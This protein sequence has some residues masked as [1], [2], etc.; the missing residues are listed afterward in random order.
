MRLTV[1][2]PT[3]NE[4]DNLRPMI[5]VLLGLD[6]SSYGVALDV[7]AMSLRSRNGT[8]MTSTPAA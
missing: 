5:E 4:A 3:Y 1:V 2:L 6:L 7:P 8:S